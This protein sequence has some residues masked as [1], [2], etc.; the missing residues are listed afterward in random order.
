MQG[1]TS[2]WGLLSLAYGN[3]GQLDQVTP[4]RQMWPPTVIRTRT[5]VGKGMMMLPRPR[6]LKPGRPDG[7][8]RRP[9]IARAADA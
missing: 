8:I 2:T 5:D 1:V 4:I 7:A 3:A 6:P 9:I